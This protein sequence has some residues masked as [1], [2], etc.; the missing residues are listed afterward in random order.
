[1]RKQKRQ[2]SYGSADELAEIYDRNMLKLIN[3]KHNA[4]TISKSIII[5]SSYHIGLD[6]FLVW[7]YKSD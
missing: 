6:V 3:Y 5:L 4:N 7:N 1:C 2:Q